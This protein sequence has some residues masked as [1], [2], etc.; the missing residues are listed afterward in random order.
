MCALRD[1]VRRD[2]MRARLEMWRVEDEL[3]QEWLQPSDPVVVS[4]AVWQAILE[5]EGL[6]GVVAWPAG[7][8]GQ[9]LV[10]GG[11]VYD[12]VPPLNGR[13]VQPLPLMEHLILEEEVAPARAIVEEQI[14]RVRTERRR[15][16]N[17]QDLLTQQMLGPSGPF[18]SWTRRYTEA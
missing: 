13:A 1:C 4:E 11:V 8:V 14:V 5:S 10:V 17:I 9:H 15:R 18:M 6:L 7:Q 2:E 12:I 16:R 3:A